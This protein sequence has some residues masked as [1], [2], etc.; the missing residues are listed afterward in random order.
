MSS[1]KTKLVFDAGDNTAIFIEQ[2]SNPTQAIV[3]PINEINITKKIL[4]RKIAISSTKLSLV[5]AW[6]FNIFLIKN[7][8]EDSVLSNF[9]INFILFSATIFGILLFIK[10]VDNVFEKPEKDLMEDYARKELRNMKNSNIVPE[11]YIIKSSFL[12]SGTDGDF[13]TWYKQERN[14]RADQ[15]I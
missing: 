1:R 6:I 5:L 11:E 3:Y 9:A 15:N 10:I 12:Y 4:K 13:I 8:L 2:S 7:I 14:K